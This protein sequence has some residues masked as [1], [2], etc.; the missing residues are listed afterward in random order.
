MI[1]SLKTVQ[2]DPLLL[3]FNNLNLIVVTND[4][5]T[6]VVVGQSE[7]LLKTKDDKSFEMIGA[8]KTINQQS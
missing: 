6:G 3:S 8:Q 7:V 5:F 2:N 1:V 4:E